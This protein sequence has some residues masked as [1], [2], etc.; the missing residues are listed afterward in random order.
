[1]QERAEAIRRRFAGPTGVSATLD[2]ARGAA[3]DAFAAVQPNR[4]WQLLTYEFALHAARN[5]K[6]AKRYVEQEDGIRDAI[7]DVIRE[8]AEALGADPPIS[9]RDLAIGLNALGIGLGLDALVDETSVPD[10]LFGTLVGFLVRGMFAA[11][12]EQAT[13]IKGDST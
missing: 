8:R 5:S 3:D 13:S 11:S 9:P 1:L 4:E 6:F 10:D 12:E 2:Q 7:E